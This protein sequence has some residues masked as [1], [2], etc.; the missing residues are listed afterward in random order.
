MFGTR[1]GHLGGLCLRNKQG[2][3]LRKWDLG[4]GGP[5]LPHKALGVCDLPPECLVLSPLLSPRSSHR[6]AP[7]FLGYRVTDLK[8]HVSWGQEW[9]TAGHLYSWG[10]D[11][12][13]LGLPSEVPLAPGWFTVLH[14]PH[15][16]HR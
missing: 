9:V 2:K 8:S 4:G 11:S 10:R 13:P 15:L 3:T 7:S 14:R 5:F 6:W 16:P 12:V 1:L